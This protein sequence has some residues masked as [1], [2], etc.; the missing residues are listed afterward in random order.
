MTANYLISKHAYVVL[1]LVQKA[2]EIDYRE[3]NR[4]CIKLLTWE[5]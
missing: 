2:V 3:L 1:H 5:L 4:V